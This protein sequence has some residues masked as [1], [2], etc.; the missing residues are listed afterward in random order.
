MP[1]LWSCCLPCTETPGATAEPEQ[2]EPG[3]SIWGFFTPGTRGLRSREGLVPQARGQ[4]LAPD[5][6]RVCLIP[7]KEATPGT[8]LANSAPW[9]AAAKAGLA[10][11]LP[12]TRARTVCSASAAQG[13]CQLGTRVPLA[14]TLLWHSVAWRGTA[15][16][17][18]SEKQ[19][20]RGTA[21]ADGHGV[22]GKAGCPIL[23][24]P[25]PDLHQGQQ[26]P[27]QSC[28]KGCV[29][30]GPRKG[31]RDK[32]SSWHRGAATQPV[33][34]GFRAVPVSCCHP[35]PVASVG[36]LEIHPPF[37]VCPWRWLHA[38]DPA[39]RGGSGVPCP[40]GQGADGSAGWQGRWAAAPLGAAS[41]AGEHSPSCLL[42]C[43]GCARSQQGQTGTARWG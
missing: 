38:H 25:G 39:Q 16:G 23:C 9:A 7:D 35:D 26:H 24:Q 3:S 5:L 15:H 12:S 40:Q 6:R 18:G 2:G 29:A 42:A 14:T 33:L 8:W 37:P 27:G 13:W 21:R 36:H 28:P 43:A 11:S 1:Q 4:H 32:D 17:T 41:P 31:L 34:K 30:T 19:P 10:P 22:Q 20:A